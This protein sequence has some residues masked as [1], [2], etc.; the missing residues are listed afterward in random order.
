MYCIC[1]VLFGRIINTLLTRNTQR[2]D[3]TQENFLLFSHSLIYSIKFILSKILYSLQWLDYGLNY[4]GFDSRL[5]QDIF[6]LL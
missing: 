4:A 6:L 2:D 5:E 3:V 1:M